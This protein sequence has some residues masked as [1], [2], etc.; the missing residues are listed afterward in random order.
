M[1]LAL[2]RGPRD[3]GEKMSDERRTNP[4]AP[5]EL[6]VDY[7]TVGSFVTNFSKDVSTGG[8]FIRTSAPLPVGTRVR[9][10]LAL[11]GD[12]LP[13]ALDGVVEWERGLH[14]SESG[15]AGMGVSFENASPELVAGLRRLVA[16]PVG[17]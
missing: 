13:V 7:R 10:R 6:K 11:P 3:A 4:R 15:P 14:E 2:L 17:D 5:V 9:L 1:A 12:A 16:D 8:V